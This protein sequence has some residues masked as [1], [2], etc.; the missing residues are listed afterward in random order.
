MNMKVFFRIVPT[1]FLSLLTV[2]LTHG[3]NMPQGGDV[4]PRYDLSLVPARMCPGTHNVGKIVLAVHNNGNFGYSEY[5]NQTDCFTGV[6]APYCE[7]PKGSNTQ[8]LYAGCFWIGAI[9]GRDTLVSVGSDGWQHIEEMFPYEAPFGDMVYRSIIDP[10]KP[11]F[12]GAVSEQDYIAVYTDTFTTGVPGLGND[13][14]DGRPHRPLYIEVTQRSYAWSYPYAEDFV[15]F[16]YSIKNIGTET[17]HNVYMGIYVDADVHQQGAQEGFDDDI[18]GFVETFTNPYGD[19]FFEDTVFVAWIADNDGDLRASGLLTTPVPNVTATRIVRTPSDELEVS[20]NWWISNGTPSLDFGPRKKIQNFRDLGTG[21]LGTPEGDRN[22]YDFLRNREFDYDQVYTA[23]IGPND[24]VWLYPNQTL[25]TTFSQ[26]YDTRYLL[27]FGPFNIEPTYTLPLSFAYLGGENFHTIPD[28]ADNNLINNYNPDAFYENLNFDDLSLNAMWAS[29]VYDNPGVDTDND[30]MFGEYRLCCKDSVMDYIDTIDIGPPLVTDT[31]WLYNQCDTFWFKGDGSPDFRGA[32]PPPSPASW[33]T[34]RVLPQVGKINIRWNGLRSENTRDVFS[35]EYDFEGYRVYLARDSRESS[36]ILLAS[37]DIEDYNRLVYNT[38][39]AE[40][41]LTETPFTLE[42][43]RCLYGDTVNGS[44]CN[45]LNFNPA[46]YTRGNPL[47][48]VDTANHTVVY[49]F[50]P[51]D[52]NRSIFANYP[53]ANTPIRKVY[54]NQPYPSNLNPD[55]ADTSEL[56]GEGYFKYFEY[57]YTIDNL[58]PT[59]PYYVNVTAFDYG[60]PQSGLGALETSKTVLARMVYPLNSVDSVEAKDLEVYVYPN[61]YRVDGN[62]IVDGYE[63]RDATYYI[64]DRLRRLH[65]VNLPAKCT[66]RIFTL[67]GDLVREIEH[68]KD[69]SD[70]TAMHDEWD[71]I[72]RNTQRIVTGIYYWV[73]E[74]DRGNTQIGKFVIIM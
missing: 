31:F 73:V 53:D 17:L 71:M 59:V 44:P 43:L 70:P 54:P 8:Y 51:Q 55:S 24:P 28:N 10:A 21:G 46:R 5:S 63:G 40:W 62:Y 64:P 74:D 13:V 9:I 23:T 15:L 66:I 7:Y 27:S 69:P 42:E 14:I 61:P 67:D 33:G 60:S 32:S 39:R 50:E 65:F 45:D 49:A 41:E 2:S 29:W 57:E 19:C 68:D 38:V 52:F 20:F 34:M 6:V 72:T 11:E 36:Y 25:A 18:C 1:L 47:F 4:K 37:Y 3:R 30:S 35:R 26:G 56:T 48:T 12:Q 58:L 16:D 22:K